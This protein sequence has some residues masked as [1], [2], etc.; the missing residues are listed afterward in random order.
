MCLKYLDKYEENEDLVTFYLKDYPSSKTSGN[1][2]SKEL[3]L[4]FFDEPIIN[5]NRVHKISKLVYEVERKQA[6][7]L[8][9]NAQ[10]FFNKRITTCENCNWT[11][12]LVDGPVIATAN[13]IVLKTKKYSSLS[14]QIAYPLLDKQLLDYLPDGLKAAVSLFLKDAIKLTKNQKDNIYHNILSKDLSKLSRKVK[15]MQARIEFV[16][17]FKK[18]FF[19]KKELK[20]EQ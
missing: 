4:H 3:Y 11:N 5:L 2:I 15:E 17:F 12:D 10:I 16:K 19:Y 8:N 14:K 7:C 6:F 1:K 18:A 20:K 13:T 9:C